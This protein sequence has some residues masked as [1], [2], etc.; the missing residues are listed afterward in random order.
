MVVQSNS[1]S[2]EVEVGGSGIQGQ[3]GLHKTLSQP[4]LPQRSGGRADPQTNDIKKSI[5][6]LCPL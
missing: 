6:H 1:S 2:C 4:L 5:A 3:P